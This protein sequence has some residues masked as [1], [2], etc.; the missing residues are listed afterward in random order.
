MTHREYFT[1]YHLSVQE[2]GEILV[3]LVFEVKKEPSGTKGY[4][5]KASIS[6]QEA[7]IEVKS[8]LA[9]TRTGKATVVHCHNNKFAKG[10]MTHLAVVLVDDYGK[11]VEAWLV[12]RDDAQR[13]RRQ[14]TKSKYIN[15]NQLRGF[16]GKQNITSKLDEAAGREV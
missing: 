5:V 11:V 10:A 1:K 9:R 7:R 3:A 14:N 15:V 12:T 13:L 6:G 2:Y 4:D 8:K 16:A